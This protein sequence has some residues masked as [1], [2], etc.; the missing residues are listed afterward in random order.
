VREQRLVFGEAPELYDRAR[1]GYSDALVEDVLAHVGLAASSCR[2][3]EVG[4]GTGK[5]TVAFARNGVDVHAL[6]PDPRMAEIA[7][8]NCE[9]YRHVE[10]EETSF[11]DWAVQ[12]KAFDLLFSAQAWHWV[13]PE[14]RCPRAAEAIVPG[15]SLALF[16][17]RVRWKE[18]DPVRTALDACYRQLAPG[19]AARGPGFPGLAVGT[20]EEE[21]EAEVA[22]CSDFVDVT[23]HEHPWE[24]TF[25]AAGYVERLRTQS[26]HRL[27]PPGELE[28]L[29]E[30]VGDVIVARGGV[31]TVPHSTI[32][33]LGRRAT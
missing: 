22:S 16:W 17:H 13:S 4:A 27:V 3:L 30:A 5:A 7:R 20:L 15:G 11:E 10:I 24:Q 19:L 25:D 14:V 1:P 12:G 23:V 33:V 32:L 21:A 29:L 2:A 8:R 6:E 31:V 18:D 28:R 26:D 9:P